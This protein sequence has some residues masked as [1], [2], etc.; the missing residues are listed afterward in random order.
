MISRLKQHK[1]DVIWYKSQY[2]N[3]SREKT[4]PEITIDFNNMAKIISAKKPEQG[5]SVLSLNFIDFK[6]DESN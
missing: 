1:N 3:E 2:S 5:L 6:K 4:S